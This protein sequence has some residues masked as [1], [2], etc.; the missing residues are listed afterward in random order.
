MNLLNWTLY[1]FIV[2]STTISS[3]FIY[4]HFSFGFIESH[5]ETLKKAGI[6]S[7]IL[8]FL[9]VVL[10]FVDA[11]ALKINIIGMKKHLF[12]VSFLAPITFFSALF[13]FATLIFSNRNCPRIWKQFIDKY[14]LSGE[15]TGYLHAKTWVDRVKNISQVDFQ[16]FKYSIQV[17]ELRFK[18]NHKMLPPTFAELSSI[19]HILDTCSSKNIFGKTMRQFAL[20]EINSIIGN[21]YASTSPGSNLKAQN[22]YEKFISNGSRAKTNQ[23]TESAK[24]NLGNIYLY[25]NNFEKAGSIFEKA[26]ES[27]SKFINLSVIYF[28]MNNFDLG[29]KAIEN[30]FTYLNRQESSQ[31]NNICALSSNYLLTLLAMQRN[32]DAINWF[33]IN[34]PKF[35]VVPDQG[36]LETYS[37][38]LLTLNKENTDSFIESLTVLSNQSKH[39]LIGIQAIISNDLSNAVSNFKQSFGID[40]SESEL[41]ILKKSKDNL[42]GTGYYEI[43]KIKTAIDLHMLKL[44]SRSEIN[45]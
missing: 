8:F 10:F 6:P 32:E 25:Q 18:N 43:F 37:V 20:A 2:I 19:A 23:W 4:R 39:L 21:L 44:S 13:L 33:Q 40:E 45:I 22:L 41:E 31:P 24:L 29:I 14:F 3:V 16:I 27:A 34:F 9:S 11:D 36:L 5:F 12:Q 30:G 17:F 7:S 38:A 1:L 35:E 15:Q 28:R 42:I 26:N